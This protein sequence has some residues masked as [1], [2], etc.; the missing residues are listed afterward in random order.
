M[1]RQLNKEIENKLDEIV[2]FIKNTDS[3][4]NYLKSKELLDKKDDIKEKIKEI[5]LYQKQ[6]VNNINKKQELELKIKE[7]LN[8]LEEDITYISYQ[9]YLNEVNNMLI[10]FENKLNKYFDEVI[11]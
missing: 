7:N 5:K 11:N 1:V 10:I 4:K 6:I 8:Y 2:Y 3:Y 9:E